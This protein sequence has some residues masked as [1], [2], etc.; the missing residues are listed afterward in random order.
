MPRYKIV[1]L[2]DITRSNPSRQESDRVKIGQQSNFNSLVQAIGLRSNVT[3]QNDPQ[4]RSGRLPEPFDGRGTYWDWDF[5]VEQEQIFEKDND[6]VGLL[7][8]DINGVPV[9]TD[10]K[11]SSEINPAVFLSFGNKNIHIEII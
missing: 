2:V 1:T 8:E 10:L 6:P 11:E 4:E 3:W 5:E 7:K 9:V